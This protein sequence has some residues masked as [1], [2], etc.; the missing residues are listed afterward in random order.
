MEYDP[1]FAVRGLHYDINRG[2][3]VKVD[4]FMQ[5]QLGCVYRGLTQLSDEEVLRIYGSRKIPLK[6]ID[7]GPGIRNHSDACMVQ[8]SDIFSVPEMNLLC[9]VAEYLHQNNFEFTPE[10]LF[11]DV[12]VKLK[13]EISFCNQ[14]LNMN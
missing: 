5:I 14:V 12:K 4:S 13:S 11:R 8:L 2:L 9:N 7:E 6:Y 3:L 1:K 10:S